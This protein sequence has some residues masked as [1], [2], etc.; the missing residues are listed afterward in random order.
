MN[1]PRIITPQVYSDGRGQSFELYNKSKI[2]LPNFVLDYVSYSAGNVLRGL[3]IQPKQEK[4]VTILY[5]SIFDVVVDLRD[6]P[7]FG[8]WYS[9]DLSSNRQ[10]QLFIPDGFAHGY[11][12][13][14]DFAIVHYKFTQ[15]YNPKKVKTIIWDDPDLAIDWPSPHPILSETDERGMTLQEWYN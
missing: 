6:G 7:D 4:L 11:Y 2:Q 12:V 3:H 1:E 13:Y 14:N 10:K 9:Y 5:G 8:T 15:Y